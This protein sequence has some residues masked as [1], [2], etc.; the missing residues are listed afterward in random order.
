MATQQYLDIDRTSDI[1]HDFVDG[2]IFAMAG[3]SPAHA[4]IAA[5]LAAELRT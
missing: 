4:L 5:N 2:E 3:G 1:K